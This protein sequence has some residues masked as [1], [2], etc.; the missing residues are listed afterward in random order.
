LL[1]LAFD[2]VVDNADCDK[3]IDVNGSGQLGMSKFFKAYLHDFG[4]L[5]IEKEGTKFGFHCGGSNKLEDCAGDVDSAVDENRVAVT[6]NAAKEEVAHSA[7][8]CLWRAKVGSIGMDIEDHFGCAELNFGIRM[9]R[10]IIKK[11]VDALVG[12]FCG[13]A[14]LGGNCQKSHENSWVNSTCII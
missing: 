5:C 14:L 12:L 1:S 9:C 10:H 6:W 8:L 11:L 13:V 2:G 3:I 7:T 4:L